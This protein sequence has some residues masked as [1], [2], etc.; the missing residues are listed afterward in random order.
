MPVTSF[1]IF[2]GGGPN[3]TGALGFHYWKEPGATNTYLK[4]GSAGRAIAFFAVLVSSAFPFTFAPELLV[5]TGGEMKSPRR[6]LPKA[7]KRYFWRLVIFYIG[8]VVSIG[9]I[10]PFNAKDLT[11]GGAGAKSS[12]F[13]LGFEKVGISRVYSSIINAV[14]ITSAWSSGNSFLYMSSRSLYSLAV[15]GNAPK[16]FTKCTKKGVPYMA[17][18][19]SSLFC[20][21][22]YL[23]CANSGAVVFNWF[24]NLTNTSGF[25]SW[26][27]C[28][29]TYLRFR[30]AYLAQN[31]PLD[32]IPYKS[33]L[34]PYGAYIALVAFPILTLINGFTVFFPENWSASNFLTAYVGIPIFFLI[35][36][37]HR[38]VNRSDKWAHDPME[39]DL[40]SG[41][42]IVI[43]N[44]EPEIRADTWQ[45]KMHGL[46][47]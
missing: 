20:A 4:T 6:N 3:Q 46:L 32:Q 26:T 9:I 11:D 41:V 12:A 42:D 31:L 17:V 18:A 25:I 47:T 27:C 29:I 37:G 1:I 14:I 7:A 10:C 16:I 44:E 30:K 8:C 15:A 40:H 45:K 21:L 36:L 13:V 33:F 43:A 2:C 38:F 23:N 19:A 35:Y 5:V 24:V 28:C 39:V 34:Q 22:A